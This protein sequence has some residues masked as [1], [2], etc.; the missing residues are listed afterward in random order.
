MSSDT[1]RAKLRELNQ[2]QG[3]AAKAK[4][5]NEQVIVRLIESFSDTQIRQAV[6]EIDEEIS[7][8]EKVIEEH[9]KA[10]NV[11]REELII[12]RK[13]CKHKNTESDSEGNM[14]A[15]TCKDCGHSW[16]NNLS[17]SHLYH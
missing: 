3:N 9:E 10:S 4:E 13:Y 11:L 16:V 14:T 1:L 8:H 15:V 17:I 12:F 6:A 5:K 7:K 2:E